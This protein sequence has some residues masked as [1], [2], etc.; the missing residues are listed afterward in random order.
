[1]AD[2]T[3]R[4][5]LIIQAKDD[6]SRVVQSTGGAF[7]GLSGTL[8][9]LNQEAGALVKQFIG[10]A[11]I[12]GALKGSIDAAMEAEKVMALTEQTIKATG[13]A[14]G[15][16]AEQVA[17]MAEAESRLTSIDDEVIQSGQNMLLTFKGIGGEVFPRAT[18][19]LE[20]MAVAMAKGDTSAID[21]QGTAIQL[22]KAL[23]DP[24]RGMTA[25][26]RVGV[27]FSEEQR[28]AIKEMVKMNDVAG[29]QALILAELESEFGGAAEAAGNTLAGKMQKAQNAVENLGEALGE[30]LIPVLVDA[31]DAAVTLLTWGEQIDAAFNQQLA[32]MT[33]RLK[34]GE[35]T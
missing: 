15:L 24:I 1:M 26:Q 30:K 34:S 6:A 14:A 7:K 21:L 17:R 22:G 29:A 27:T 2:S 12:I 5:T 11:A 23:N 10:P 25:L 18:R 19:A 20:D 13:G 4:A 28:K 33:A 16:T 32:N 9:S 31:A 3:R 8:K 35:V